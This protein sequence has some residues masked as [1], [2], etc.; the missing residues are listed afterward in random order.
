MAGHE[1]DHLSASQIN[2][3]LT[4]SLKYRFQYVDKIPKLFK[5]SGLAFG[6]VIH[7]T[8]DWFHKQR[9]LKKE[10][11][12]DDLYK[13]LGADWFCQG[14]E[15]EIRY[16]DG[17]DEDNLL[18]TAKGMISLYYHSPQ[19]GIVEAEFPFRLPLIN[20]ANGEKLGIPLEGFIDLIESNNTITE[21]KTSAQ[22]INS[23]SLDEMLQ[24][25]TYSYAYQMIFGKEAQMLKVI[26][27]VKT[28][29]PKMNVLKSVARE[30]KNYA[31]LF[32]LAKEVLRS[33][34]SKIFFPRQSFM[35]KDCEYGALC[36]VW[37]GN[38]SH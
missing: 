18:A 24:L 25:T 1:I 11:S 30:Q 28:K 16:K 12:L 34:R 2:L 27:F 37:D 31:R 35:C 21:F 20:P 13:I 36:K 17:E 14:C 32:H 3:Y 22:S 5:P 9:K 15:N 8:I 19:N 29:I 33:V 10:V 7:S 38:G 23:D 4:C 6:S 26:N